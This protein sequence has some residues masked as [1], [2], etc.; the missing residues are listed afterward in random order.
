MPTTGSSGLNNLFSN[1]AV[2]QTTLPS[3]YDTAQQNIVNQAGTAQAAAPSFGQTTAQGAVNT[4]TGPA[5][6]FT[7]AQNTLQQ[8]SSGAANPWITDA[9]GNVTPNTNTALGGLFAAQ[10]QQ[11]NQLMPNVTAPAQANA[12]A[13]GNFGSLR[14]QTAVNKAKADAIANLTAQQLAS[15]L[16]NQQTGSQAA[17]NLGN[18]GAQGITAGLT[19]GTAQMNAPF[20]G[21]TNYANLINSIQAPATASQQ[22]QLSPLNMLGSAGSAV[23]GVLGALSKS[24]G[25]MDLLNS[26]GLGKWVTSPGTTTNPFDGTVTQ[27]PDT[28]DTGTTPLP[29]DPS[30]ADPY[31]WNNINTTPGSGETTQGAGYVFE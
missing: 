21:L 11:L 24:Q 7:Q 19:T 9:S 17:A 6:P 26:L 8:I 27:T 13:S 14:G 5:N 23:T 16:Q 29:S 2:T 31:N 30:S 1:T 15:A 3:W 20:Q 28:T 22:T 25:G 4:L 10:N 18:V 12:I